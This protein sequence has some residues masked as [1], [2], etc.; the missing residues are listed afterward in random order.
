MI[1]SPTTKRGKRCRLGAKAQKDLLEPEIT[2]EIVPILEFAD[3]IVATRI[4]LGGFRRQ[5]GLSFSRTQLVQSCLRV[6]VIAKPDGWRPDA[7]DHAEM[8]RQLCCVAPRESATDD[9]FLQEFAAA[10]R[11]GL[12]N[13]L[14]YWR[15]LPD[16]KGSGPEIISTFDVASAPPPNPWNVHAI[17]FDDERAA[18][19]I[20]LAWAGHP[21]AAEVLSDFIKECVAEGS[22]L[23]PNLARYVYELSAGRR[24][25]SLTKRISTTAQ[26]DFEIA[27]LIL[28][29]LKTGIQRSAGKPGRRRPSP[30]AY[31][32]AQRALANNG[33]HVSLPTIGSAWENFGEFAAEHHTDPMDYELVGLDGTVYLNP[34]TFFPNGEQHIYR[35][36]IPVL[37]NQNQK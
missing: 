6:R 15:R 24:P 37:E 36:V 25:E 2:P 14:L 7:S 8:E 22:P 13:H 30:N 4:R 31:W 5:V 11:F 17:E 28:D 18:R 26:R 12:W 9:E 29:L 3:K 21:T 32:V 20:D 1:K 33:I 27:A 16:A 23:P 19:V 34:R 35:Q 10:I